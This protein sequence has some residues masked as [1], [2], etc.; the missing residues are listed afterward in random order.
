MSECV[1]QL[2]CETSSLTTLHCI[3]AI[4]PRQLHVDSLY[5]G[6]GSHSH[7]RLNVIESGNLCML[8]HMCVCV[9]M[10]ALSPLA[11]LSADDC[12]VFVPPVIA[13]D[14]PPHSPQID[15]HPAIEL[16]AASLQTRRAY[17]VEKGLGGGGITQVIH[18]DSIIDSNT[19]MTSTKEVMF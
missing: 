5:A 12:S 3:L 14:R 7:L 15:F 11:Q 9:C 19:L 13:A 8:G 18:S 4:C 16:G 2:R 1:R 17:R 6:C 10:C